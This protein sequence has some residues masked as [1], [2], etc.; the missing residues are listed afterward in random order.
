MDK[1][2]DDWLT[3]LLGGL[4]PEYAALVLLAL[5]ALAAWIAYLVIGKKKS[6]N[7][8]DQA[9][10]EIHEKKTMPDFIRDTSS[11]MVDHGN[12]KRR[13]NKQGANVDWHHDRIAQIEFKLGLKPPRMRREI[14]DESDG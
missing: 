12:T 13:V 9:L 10:R 5:I 7:N 4:P 1:L 2:P 14:E 3:Q 6:K 11:L 8:E